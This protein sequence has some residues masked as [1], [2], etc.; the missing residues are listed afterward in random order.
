MDDATTRQT[1]DEERHSHSRLLELVRAA[2][3]A[4]GDAV[5]E[6]VSQLAHYLA[7]HF[8]FEEAPTGWMARAIQVAPH[9]TELVEDLQAEHGAML[10]AARGLAAG[11]GDAVSLHQLLDLIESHEAREAMVIEEID[12]RA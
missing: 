8:G 5:R 1:L 7:G 11:H 12:P 3:D 4:E 6:P 9:R 10:A 2:R